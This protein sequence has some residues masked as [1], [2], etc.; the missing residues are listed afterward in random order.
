[1]LMLMYS[2]ML[3]QQQFLDQNRHIFSYIGYDFLAQQ[4]NRREYQNNGVPHD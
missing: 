1:M 2:W 3:M 4:A